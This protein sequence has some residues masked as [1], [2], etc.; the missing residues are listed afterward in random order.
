MVGLVIVSHSTKIAQGVCEMARQMAGP[1][2][3]IIAAGGTSEGEIGTDAMKISE[4]IQAADSGEGVVIMVDLGS[5]V[6]SADTA[7]EFLDD[8]LRSRVHIADAPIVEGSISAAVQAS[9]GASLE[10]VLETAEAAR[11]LHKK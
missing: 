4:A 11:E 10:E 5:A 7:L 6:L 1:E 2:Q 9:V 8:E 3:K